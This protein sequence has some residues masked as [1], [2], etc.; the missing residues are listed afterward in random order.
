MLLVQVKA[1]KKGGI[2]VVDPS[3]EMHP[4]IEPQDLWD[5]MLS[6]EGA[7]PTGSPTPVDEALFLQVKLRRNA[8][9]LIDPLAEMHNCKDP[10]D[11]WDTVADLIENDEMPVATTSATTAVAVRAHHFDVRTD[12]Q[13]QHRRQ[14]RVQV[15]SDDGEDH[16]HRDAVRDAIEEMVG[17]AAADLGSKLFSRLRTMSHRAGAPKPG[18]RRPQRRVKRGDIY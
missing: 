7:A 6:F 10:H 15:I 5:V 8:V 4:C 14:E 2:V 16:Q 1:S 11:L 12:M 13:H 3:G 18:S 9:I 17:D